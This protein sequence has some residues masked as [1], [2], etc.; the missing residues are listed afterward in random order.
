MVGAGGTGSHLFHGL[1]LY[2]LAKGLDYHTIHIWDADNVEEKNLERQAFFQH[3]IG[4]NKAEA[5]AQR[6]VTHTRPHKE[7]VG[8]NNIE[9]VMQDGDIVFI[10]ADN[11]T[12]RRLINERAKQLDNVTVINGGNELT[13]GSVQLFIRKDGVNLTPP[14]DWFSPELA[15]EDGDRSELSCADIA[16]LPGGEQTIIANQTVAALM[17]AA[18]WRADNLPWEATYD[19]LTTP[20]Q[21]TKFTFDH[22]AGTTQTSDVRLTGGWN[23]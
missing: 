17:L 10:C 11:M 8:P 6:F 22:K 13:S 14:L 3:D 1:Y 4:M 18:L 23:A 21:W 5:L 12:V 16:A 15:I 9:L 7:Y 19:P 20:A 2:A